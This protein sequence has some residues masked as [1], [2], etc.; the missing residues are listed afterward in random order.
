MK[1]SVITSTYN[2]ERFIEDS[3]KSILAQTY[4]DFEFIIVDDGSTD[5]TYRIV[6]SFDDKRIKYIRCIPNVGVPMNT[7][8]AIDIADGE[9]IAIQDADDISLPTRLEQEI[10]MLESDKSLFCVG[11]YAIIINEDGLRMKEWNHPP[12][13]N[14]GMIDIIAS[15]KNPIINPSVM[16]KRDD[17]IEIGK[18]TTEKDIQ[19]VHDLE[20]WGRCLFSG[21][22]FCTLE[23]PLIKYR[24]NRNGLT[25]GRSSEMRMSHQMLL[26]RWREKGLI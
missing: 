4:D 12:N 13:S 24:I 7:N 20:F 8:F 25:F 5:D 22:N 6:G 19:L 26:K 17:F 16:F 15:G 2:S 18:Y 10:K 11:G 23:T 14:S 3:I 1:I 9:Y 21:L